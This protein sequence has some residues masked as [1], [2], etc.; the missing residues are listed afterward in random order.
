MKKLKRNEFL[1]RV[2]EKQVKIIDIFSHT[3]KEVKL[4]SLG[5]MRLAFVF[6]N[7]NV[8]LGTSFLIKET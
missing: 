8:F 3:V 4:F 1:V 2:K 6:Q 5:K 7:C